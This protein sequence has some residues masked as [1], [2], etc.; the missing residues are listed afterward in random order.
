ML[1]KLE[2]RHAHWMAHFRHGAVRWGLRTSN[3]MQTCL[4]LGPTCAK[5]SYRRT[6]CFSSRGS[7]VFIC[8]SSVI[9]SRAASL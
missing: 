4:P 7:L 5:S 6:Q 3:T 8:V 9:S 2:D 1:Y